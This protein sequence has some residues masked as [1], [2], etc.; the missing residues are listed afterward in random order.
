MGQRTGD[1]VNGNKHLADLRYWFRTMSQEEVWKGVLAEKGGTTQLEVLVSEMMDLGS[2]ENILR[3]T[4]RPPQDL[5]EAKSD[6]LELE[7]Y[8]EAWTRRENIS[9]SRL[10]NGRVPLVLSCFW[11][12][13][14]PDA[15]PIFF[16]VVR[17]RFNLLGDVV[18]WLY[19][20][21]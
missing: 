17:D 9:R 12:F 10:D 1:F 2:V 3:R 4:I 14:E 7:G 11:H 21:N 13:Q 15:W 16:E 6:M 8:I 18:F 20:Y 5:E 19:D